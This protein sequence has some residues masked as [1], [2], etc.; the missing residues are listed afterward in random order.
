MSNRVVITGM[1]VVSPLGNSIDKF[2]E[3]I[4]KGKNGIKDI[5]LFDTSKYQIHIGG[6]CEINLNNYIDAKI[7]KKIDRFI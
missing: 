4:K 6:E 3:S 1:G 5:T 2:W 7:L